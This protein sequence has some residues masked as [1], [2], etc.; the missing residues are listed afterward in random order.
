[1]RNINYHIATTIDGYICHED[2]S[3]DGF[4]MEGEHADE[5]IESLEN[6][7]T[8]LMGSRTYEFGFQFGLEEGQP[9]YPRL[10]H[11]VFSHSLS[12]ESSNSVTL[13]KTS[14]SDIVRE[15]KKVEGKDIWVCGGG[16]LAGYLIDNSLIDKLTL[17][18]NPVVFGSGRKLFGNSKKNVNVNLLASKSYSN[19]VVLN[20]YNIINNA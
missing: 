6:Y 19:G 11:Y 20:E 5:F 9:A 17:K 7:D 15:L 12:F 10:K 8:V 18:I 3:I 14:A 2:G 16:E 4:L 1:M 13:V